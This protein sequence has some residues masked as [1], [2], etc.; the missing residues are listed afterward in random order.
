MWGRFILVCLNVYSV[1]S[2]FGNQ[3]FDIIS[4]LVLLLLLHVWVALGRLCVGV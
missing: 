4:H 2:L 3:C 1:V